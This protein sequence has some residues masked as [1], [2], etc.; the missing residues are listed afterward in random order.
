MAN[1][2]QSPAETF[3]ANQEA[4]AEDAASASAG[5]AET[6][7]PIPARELTETRCSR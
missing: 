7:V 3:A 5:R 4:A 6:E 1:N 2:D